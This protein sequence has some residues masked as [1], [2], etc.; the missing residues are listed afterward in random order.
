MTQRL[1]HSH[2]NQASKLEETLTPNETDHEEKDGLILKSPTD[3][4]DDLESKM[5]QDPD[6]LYYKLER[7]KQFR[8]QKSGYFTRKLFS[9]GI[10]KFEMGVN[11]SEDPSALEGQSHGADEALMRTGRLFGGLIADI[12]RKSKFYISDFRDALHMQSLAAIIYIYLAT[13]TKAITFGGFLSDITGGM[14]GVLE[15]FLGHALAGG[16][17]CLFG[18]QPLTVLGNNSQLFV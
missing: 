14:Q 6:N 18:G 13:I 2:A 11:P 15:S 3:S 7:G 16:V 12:K 9:T 4:S 8:K 1:L 17:F 5:E 10:S